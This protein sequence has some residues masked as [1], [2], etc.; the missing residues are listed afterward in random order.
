MRLLKDYGSLTDVIKFFEKIS[1]F[2]SSLLYLKQS[3]VKEQY[4]KRFPIYPQVKIS[5]SIHSVTLAEIFLVAILA[6]QCIKYRNS[7]HI[8]QSVS[9][10]LL[11]LV[12]SSIA[13]TAIVLYCSTVNLPEPMGKYGLFYIDFV[14]LLWVWGFISGSFK[15]CSQVCIDYFGELTIDTN[16]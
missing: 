7:R 11:G 6:Y 2:L 13:I 8:F 12:I 3:I 10:S 4:S 16:L 14:D 1:F 5:K 9:K 15:F